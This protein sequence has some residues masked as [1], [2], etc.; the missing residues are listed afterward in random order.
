MGR[1]EEGEVL[2]KGEGLETQLTRERRRR[3]GLQGQNLDG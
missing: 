3:E 1:K 2:V